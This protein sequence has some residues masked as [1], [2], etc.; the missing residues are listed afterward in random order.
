MSSPTR[1]PSP[2]HTKTLCAAPILALAVLMQTSQ[3]A[4]CTYSESTTSTTQWSAGTSW[5]ATPASAADTALIFSATQAAGVNTI[6]NNDIAGNF[7]L[8]SLNFTYAGPASGTAPTL[9]ISGNALAFTSNGATTQTLTINPTGT[10]R[11][12]LTITNNLIL[13]NNLTLSNPSASNT[14]TL[15]GVISG[16]GGISKSGAGTVTIS[17]TANNQP[18]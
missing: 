15:S 16:S 10:S 17:N 18:S 11:P 7:T 1:S 12:S 2:L 9:T 13:S 5:S 3:A 6:S 14:A 4:N 8:N